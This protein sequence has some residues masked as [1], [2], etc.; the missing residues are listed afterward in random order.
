MGWN[1][2][3]SVCRL[4]RD[5]AKFAMTA[6]LRRVTTL[7]FKCIAA[8]LRRVARGERFVLSHRGRPAARL[9]PLA[10]AAPDPANDPFA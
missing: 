7:S 10:N 2:V 6:R 4:K 5:P 8:P 1:E 9:E 3:D